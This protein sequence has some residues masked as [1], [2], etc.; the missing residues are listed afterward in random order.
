[1]LDGVISLLSCC[2]QQAAKEPIPKPPNRTQIKE[3][4]R[5]VS[6]FGLVFLQSHENIDLTPIR[7]SFIDCLHS[8]LI[9]C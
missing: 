7:S 9:K 5:V 4:K 8:P 2:L 3:G 1:M 6:N